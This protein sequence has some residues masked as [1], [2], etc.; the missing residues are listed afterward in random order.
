MSMYNVFQKLKCALIDTIYLLTTKI[1]VCVHYF[2][3]KRELAKNLA[4]KIKLMR[5]KKYTKL[6]FEVIIYSIGVRKKLDH[7]YNAS[8]KYQSLVK[9]SLIDDLLSFVENFIKIRCE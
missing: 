1:F 3:R 9:V 5:I 7:E 8:K 4:T 6:S 2:K